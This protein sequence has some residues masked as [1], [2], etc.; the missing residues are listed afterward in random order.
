MKFCTFCENMLYVDVDQE[1]NLV[2]YCKSCSNKITQ[3]KD[4]G[5]VTIVDDNKINNYMKYSQYINK[6]LK[7]DP[8]LPRVSNMVCP[9]AACT[10]KEDEENEVIFIKYDPNDMKYVYYCCFCSHSWITD[11]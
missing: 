1:K 7:F 5:S 4:A 8:T 9:N 3:P 11:S 2:Y 10:K 6:Y